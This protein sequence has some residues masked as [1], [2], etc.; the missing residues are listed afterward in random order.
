MICFAGSRFICYDQRKYALMLVLVPSCPVLG[1]CRV[2]VVFLPLF[3]A[4]TIRCRV[5]VILPSG[6]F[7][8]LTDTYIRRQQLAVPIRVLLSC[9]ALVHPRKPKRR[10]YHTY[11]ATL[12]EIAPVQSSPAASAA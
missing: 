11:S 12:V 1:I 7:C 9:D 6:L 8:P 3:T 5:F 4:A 10:R 2:T